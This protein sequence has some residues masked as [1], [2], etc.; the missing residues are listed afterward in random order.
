MASFDSD[1]P[2]VSNREEARRKLHE[3]VDHL[4]AQP[5]VYLM[6]GRDGTIIYIGKAKSLKSRV[7]SYFTPNAFDGRAQFLALVHSVWSLDYI[8]T[9]N[10]VEAL[11]LEANLV[12][13]HKP[14]YNVTLKDDK[15]YP[16]VRITNEPFPRIFLTRDIVE[17]GS[18]YL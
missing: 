13:L 16:F 11:V 9:D 3:V 2:P 6:R 4:P 1:T 15:K 5:G 12:K 18:R 17:D 10:E 7:R 14:R 8:V